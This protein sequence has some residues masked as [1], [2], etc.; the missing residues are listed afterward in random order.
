MALQGRVYGISVGGN[1][2]NCEISC[3]LDVQREMINKSGSHGGS[4]RFYRPSYYSWSI[5]VDAK[6]VISVLSGSFN[7]LL[8]A[9]L[10]GT[11]LD[12][13]LMARVSNVQEINIGGKVLIPNLNVTFPNTGSSTFTTTFQGTGPLNV[14]VQE[15]FNIINQMPYDDPKDLIIDANT[16]L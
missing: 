14:D 15:L 11:E 9:Q 5:S 2:V 6:T 13:Y 4:A 12:V 8:K 7:N 10:A 16:W 3:S 1:F